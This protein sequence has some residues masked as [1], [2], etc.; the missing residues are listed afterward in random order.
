MMGLLH[1][2]QQYGSGGGLLNR[3]HEG[4][5]Q[6]RGSGLLGL[7]LRGAS[8]LIPKLAGL[9][10]TALK[11]SSQTIQK[12]AKSELG[13]SITDSLKDAAISTSANAAADLLSGSDPLATLQKGVEDAKLNVASALR[14]KADKQLTN[15]SARRKRKFAGD[16][17]AVKPK[18]SKK[19]KKTYDL[20]EN[21]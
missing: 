13:R 9:G 18:K 10:K 5:S 6:Q 11:A 21:N 16:M 15:S 7:I 12:A 19:K 17:T 1:I 8:K 14:Q 4:P 2:N 20:F 3:F